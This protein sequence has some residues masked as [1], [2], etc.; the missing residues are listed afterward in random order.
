MFIF[1][2]NCAMQ[3]E[4]LLATGRFLSVWSGLESSLTSFG[5]CGGGFS[6]D[7][8]MCLTAK[9]WAHSEFNLSIKY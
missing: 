3:Y 7:L 6:S 2:T 4:R 1:T 8:A 5:S 9:A